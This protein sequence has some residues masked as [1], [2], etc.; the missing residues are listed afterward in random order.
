MKIGKN[1]TTFDTELYLS[2]D[3]VAQ[4]KEM[5]QGASLP[6]RRTFCKILEL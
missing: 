2:D 6:L 4:L 3:E 1:P 5:V